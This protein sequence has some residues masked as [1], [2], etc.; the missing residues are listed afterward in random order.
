M[1]GILQRELVLLSL[2]KMYNCQQ[3]NNPSTQTKKPSNPGVKAD[4]FPQ[5]PRQ[6]S[7]LYDGW[8]TALSGFAS[9]KD[10]V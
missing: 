4:L 1:N 5:N 3:T 7:H 2:M 8:V 10:F 6:K 9:Y